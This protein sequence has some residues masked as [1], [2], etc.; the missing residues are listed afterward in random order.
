MSEYL[1]RMNHA[2]QPAGASPLEGLLGGL[3]G[4]NHGVGGL[5]SLVERLRG[6]G[7][8]DEV[9]SWVGTGENRPVDPN[10]LEQAIG[11]DQVQQFSMS[12]GIPKTTL[13]GIL[14]M[15]LPRLID[16]MTPGGHVPSRDADVPGGGLGGV[17]GSILGGGLGGLLGGGAAGAGAGPM[18]GSQ[19]TGADPMPSSGGG[20]GGLLGGL[21][22]GSAGG[23]SGGQAANEH[24]ISNA[25]RNLTGGR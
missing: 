25:W 9:E 4:G 2:A 18:G 1:N 23:A 13:L 24:D 11:S 10:R 17:L 20:L 3:M 12:H 19:P 16:R 14:A 22:G 21:L 6:A 7:L 5:G 8:N 15:L